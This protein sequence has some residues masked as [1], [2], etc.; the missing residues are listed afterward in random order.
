MP[1]ILHNVVKEGLISERFLVDWNNQKIK[2]IDTNFL[3]NA[4]R[5]ALFKKH[6]QPFLDSLD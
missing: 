6:V 5:D 1:T 2:D 3:Y 4:N